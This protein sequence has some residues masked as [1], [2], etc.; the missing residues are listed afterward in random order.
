MLVAAAG[1]ARIAAWPLHA[2]STTYD[3]GVFTVS[4]VSVDLVVT[5]LGLGLVIAPISAVALRSVPAA[6][7]GIASAAVV[8]ARMMGML[9]GVAALGAWGFHRFHAL[10]A[11]LVTPLPIGMSH[12]EYARRLAAYLAAVKSALHT[13]YADI[14][15]ATAALCAA[16]ALLAIAIGRRP[17]P[18]GP[19]PAPVE[20]GTVRPA[21]S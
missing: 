7:H 8:V 12:T 6:Q 15:W 9:I 16:A 5:G 18:A 19:A 2:Q 3:L 13:E 17:A 11:H 20:T 10:T 14:F 4:R 21:S 1:Y